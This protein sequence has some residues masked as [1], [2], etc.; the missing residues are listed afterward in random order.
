M[1]RRKLQNR[2]LI[3]GGSALLL[4]AAVLAAIQLWLRPAGPPRWDEAAMKPVLSGLLE[5]VYAAFGQVDEFAIYDGIAAAVSEDLVTPLYLQRRAAQ[6]HEEA[7]G[8]ATEILE[9]HLLEVTPR[10]RT[11]QGLLVDA[12]WQVQGRV[13]HGDHQHIRLNEYAAGL[14]LDE[15][16][17]GWQLT[18]FDLDSVQ[19]EESEPEF[20][21]GLDLFGDGQ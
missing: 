5:Q 21:D 3:A 19:R 20:F 14:T 18:G 1:S 17:D 10:A 4:L 12:V 2:L 16:A 9:L 13:G 8:A 15:S 11:P 7:S 6:L